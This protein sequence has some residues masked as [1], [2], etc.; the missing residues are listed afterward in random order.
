[1][2][3]A[4]GGIIW[5]IFVYTRLKNEIIR[6]S[7]HTL[8]IRYLTKNYPCRIRALSVSKSDL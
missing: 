7:V 6:V 2:S 8:I 1:M 5:S 4:E 3:Y